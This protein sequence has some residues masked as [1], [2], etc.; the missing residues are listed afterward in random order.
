MIII[1]TTSSKSFLGKLSLPE[2]AL[3]FLAGKEEREKHAPHLRALAEKRASLIWFTVKN[4]NGSLK[5][6]I[7]MDQ[8]QADTHPI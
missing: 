3:F 2:Y 1:N 6:G 4:F 7:G 5:T 8:S